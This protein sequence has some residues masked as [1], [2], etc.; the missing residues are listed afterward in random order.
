[1]AHGAMNN[2]KWD[3]VRLAMYELGAAHPMWRTKDYESGY[4]CPWDGEWFYHFRQ[5]GYDTIEWAEIA[6]TSQEQ[7]TLVR[8]ALRKIHVPG[9]ET[10]EG[11]RVFGYTQ[12]GVPL[13]Y[14]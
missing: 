4:V 10:P 14:I 2:T 1:M 8:D 11:F 9:E 6:V 13:S 12:P 5:G 7:R 3:E